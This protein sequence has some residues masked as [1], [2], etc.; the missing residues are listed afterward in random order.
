ML[1]LHDVRGDGSQVCR[2][3][4]DRAPERLPYWAERAAK[5]FVSKYSEFYSETL[6]TCLS[7]ERTEQSFERAIFLVQHPRYESMWQFSFERG[8]IDKITI[9]RYRPVTLAVTRMGGAILSARG[10]TCSSPTLYEC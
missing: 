8:R 4:D 10:T 6:A 9:E 5:D 2:I 1:R 7:A 3:L